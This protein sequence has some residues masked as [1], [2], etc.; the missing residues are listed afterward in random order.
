MLYS[1][2]FIMISYTRH[3]FFKILPYHIITYMIISKCSFYLSMP[4]FPLYDFGFTCLLKSNPSQRNQNTLKKK[5]PTFLLTYY[6]LSY[7]FCKLFFDFFPFFFKISKISLI[8][9]HFT[10]NFPYL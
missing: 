6:I 1:I 2:I 8:F 9:R 10:A 3:L 7:L 5:R 4:C